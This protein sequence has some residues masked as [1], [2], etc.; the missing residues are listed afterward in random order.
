MVE[1]SS[2]TPAGEEVPAHHVGLRFLLGEKKSESQNFSASD[3]LDDVLKSFYQ[4]WPE[5]WVDSKPAAANQLRVIYGG[6]LKPGTTVLSAL[7]KPGSSAIM[8]LHIAPEGPNETTRSNSV[9]AKKSRG[10]EE[11]KCTC[12]ML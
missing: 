5:E 9:S 2:P 10:S 12:T 8:H 4:S 3:T 6:G 7:V 1:S 11:R